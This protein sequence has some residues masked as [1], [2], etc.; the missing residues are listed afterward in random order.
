MAQEMPSW[1][2]G[3]WTT[4]AELSLG[5]LKGVLNRSSPRCWS[6]EF[7][8]SLE[9]WKD[10]LKELDSKLDWIL[11][12]CRGADDPV[13]WSKSR[14]GRSREDC[15]FAFLPQAVAK[16]VARSVTKEVFRQLHM[17]NAELHLV[18]GL[19]WSCF[20]YFPKSLREE[21]KAHVTPFRAAR[22]VSTQS[23]LPLSG[24]DGDPRRHCGQDLGMCCSS[25]LGLRGSYSGILFRGLRRPT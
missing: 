7:T 25:F 2:Q 22:A 4:I 9:C 6:E 16:G 8:Q 17:R 11:S 5:A 14:A 13:C 15:C 21:L 10:D 24:K 20:G 3:V 19:Y 23:M 12:C 18:K 1:S